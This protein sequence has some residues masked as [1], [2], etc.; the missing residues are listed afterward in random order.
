MPPKPRFTIAR[1]IIVVALFGVL[2]ALPPMLGAFLAGLL[3]SGVI[4]WCGVMS[5][6]RFFGWESSRRGG[7]EDVAALAILALG[8]D[9]A[10]WGLL[11]LVAL[12]FPNDSTW[13]SFVIALYLAV[14]MV[15]TLGFVMSLAAL[16]GPGEGRS[17]G[18][19]IVAFFAAITSFPFHFGLGFGLVL[20]V[21]APFH[22]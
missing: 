2:F 20:I 13:S 10:A 5:L 16:L 9:V 3:V 6:W 19:K 7:P 12:R 4:T 22:R 21:I 11:I 8:L 17:A 1:M 14:A 18:M 15:G